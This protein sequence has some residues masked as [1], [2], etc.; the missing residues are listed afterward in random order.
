MYYAICLPF[1]LIATAYLDAMALLT[2]EE[3]SKRLD[4]RAARLHTTY[5]DEDKEALL[6][7]NKDTWDAYR[8]ALSTFNDLE[9]IVHL[10]F[11]SAF[12]FKEL[13]SSPKYKV[14]PV[15]DA[16]K[17]QTYILFGLSLTSKEVLV[18]G[19]EDRYGRRPAK[20]A[21][22]GPGQD[23]AILHA[24]NSSPLRAICGEKTL[25][26]VGLFCP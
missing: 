19:S 25:E 26:D 13:L 6:E 5:S 4:D 3:H 15:V 23:A 18:S 10:S 17:E 8:Y 14:L 20:F 22:P 2:K 12:Y 16:E 1:S 9:A 21:L 7:Q 24:Y 11:E